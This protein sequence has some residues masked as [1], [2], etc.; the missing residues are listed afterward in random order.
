MLHT[1]FRRAKWAGA[2]PE[3][4]E[5][6]A[7]ALGGDKRYGMDTPIPL[8][9]IL[10]V[11]GFD[12]ALWALQIVI[13]PVEKEIKLACDYASHAL[14][15]WEERYPD[16]PRPRQAIEMTRKYINGQAT[17][18]E[19]EAARAAAGDAAGDTVRDAWAARAAWAAAEDIEAEREWQRERL[20]EILNG[21]HN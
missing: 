13:E 1:T 11:C 3:G 14:P 20:I 5:K 9:K 21:V 2:C 19:V 15:I 16:D 6:M 4:Y 10:E 18:A 8:D 7:K 12:D 17:L